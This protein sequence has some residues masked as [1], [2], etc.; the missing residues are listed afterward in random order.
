MDYKKPQIFSDIIQLKPEVLLWLPC[1]IAL[2]L[3]EEG[4]PSTL[5]THQLQ[6][7]QAQV[8]NCPV[9][10]PVLTPPALCQ[11]ARATPRTSSRCSLDPPRDFA[12]NPEVSLQ[13]TSGTKWGPH[14]SG[15][16]KDESLT[17]LPFLL[18]D[19]EYEILTEEIIPQRF[20][21]EPCTVL[22][23]DVMTVAPVVRL[24]RLPH[25]TGKQGANEM[26]LLVFICGR[27][28]QHVTVVF[29]TY[30]KAGWVPS[31]QRQTFSSPLSVRPIQK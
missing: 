16:S 12:M 13:E 31:S 3:E 4:F 21:D 7:P 9:L 11:W 23:T 19:V 27:Q 2:Q 6:Q 22:S 30:V 20:M 26:M 28:K 29:N 10:L 14:F 18:A 8:K 5:E 15:S 24:P 25:A 17:L 1:C